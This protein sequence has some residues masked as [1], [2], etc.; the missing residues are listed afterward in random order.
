VACINFSLWEE[1]LGL[2]YKG[3]PATDSRKL[4]ERK[5]ILLFAN[6]SAADLLQMGEC[7]RNV[8][9]SARNPCIRLMPWRGFL[10][11][12]YSNDATIIS[13]R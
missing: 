12:P 5:I 9:A 3:W 1:N 6:K 4:Q 11:K 7:S 13:T 8:T 10:N 2:G